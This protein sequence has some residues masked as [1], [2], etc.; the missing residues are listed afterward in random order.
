V[1][2]TLDLCATACDCGTVSVPTLTED[3]SFGIRAAIPSPTNGPLTIH[4]VLPSAMRA[5]LEVFD[6]SGERIRT[7]VDGPMPAGPQVVQWDGRTTGG[8]RVPAGAYFLRLSAGERATSRK[9][10]VVR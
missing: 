4:F 10:I 1:P 2:A 9:V 8:R 5:R 6:A 3:V 7:V